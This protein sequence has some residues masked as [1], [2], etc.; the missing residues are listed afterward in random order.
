MKYRTS[1]SN[2]VLRVALEG[3]LNF[4]ANEEFQGLLDQL[5]KA[6]P[7]QVIL[8]MGA[9]TGIDSVGLGLLYIAQEDL[10]GVGA[11]LTLASPKDNV[12]RLLELTEAAKTFEII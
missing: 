5:V 6:A 8:E 11:K 1:E 9:L 10:G 12:A 7:R 2:G 4:A 3:Q